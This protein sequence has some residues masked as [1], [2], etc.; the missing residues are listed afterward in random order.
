MH[1][2]GS[3][4]RG[5]TCFFWS[6]G[7]SP[8]RDCFKLSWSTQALSIFFVQMC[9][10]CL[11]STQY[12]GFISTASLVYWFSTLTLG[13]RHGFWPRDKV[14]RRGLVLGRF[15]CS[16]LVIPVLE[17]AMRTW[18]SCSPQFGKEFVWIM[19]A[20]EAIFPLNS[21]VRTLLCLIFSLK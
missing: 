5:W 4:G 6:M 1:G 18:L 11:P 17:N 9:T 3:P 2:V 8:T 14:W 7:A 21:R 16:T 12:V 20:S 10:V 19:V 15:S 13:N